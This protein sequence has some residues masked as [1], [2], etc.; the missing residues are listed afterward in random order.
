[1]AAHPAV[2]RAQAGDAAES[3]GRDDRADRLGTDRERDQA[4]GDGRA[5]SARG[6]AAPVRGIPRIQARTR[7]RRVRVVV[8][9]AARELD[10]RELRRENRPGGLEFSNHRG[11]V[12]E[13]LVA[14][15]RRAPGRR[16]LLRREEVLRAVRDAVER[17]AVFSAADLP[18]RRP[19]RGERIFSGER[20]DRVQLSP[21]R[22]EPV[23]SFLHERDG[24]DLARADLRRQPS[25]RGEEVRAGVGHFRSTR[26]STTGSSPLASL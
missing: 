4:R 18:L 12:S 23:E 6:A 7:E 11:V 10:H 3:G 25:E 1:M 21:V 20:H 26:K 2:R 5:R 22:F 13:L 16:H 15:R 24:R 17:A 9:H 14:I 8:A 19:G